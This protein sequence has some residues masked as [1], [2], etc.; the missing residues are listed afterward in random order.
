MGSTGPGQSPQ[1]LF[2]SLAGNCALPACKPTATIAERTKTMASN[3]HYSDDEEGYIDDDL[4][5][6]GVEGA[7]LSPEGKHRP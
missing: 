4:S 7:D 5:Q 6:D 1:G 3:P 2:G